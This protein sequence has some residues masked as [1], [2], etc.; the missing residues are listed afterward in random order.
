L[1]KYIAYDHLYFFSRSIFERY[2]KT[3]TRADTTPTRGRGIGIG[4]GRGRSS[5]TVQAPG[6]GRGFKVPLSGIG[7]PKRT[8][9]HE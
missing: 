4:R 5:T 2:Q 6:R 1:G 8:S 7:V 3:P 9:L